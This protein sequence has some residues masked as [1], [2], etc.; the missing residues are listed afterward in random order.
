MSLAM[1]GRNASYEFRWRRWALLRDTAALHL[2]DGKSGTRFPRFASIGDALIDPLRIPARELADEIRAMQPALARHPV[3]ALVLG[4][5]TAAILYMGARL[6]SPRPLTNAEIAQISPLGDARNL[7][8][9]F[10]SMLDSMSHV[11]QHAADDG[12]IEVI[13]G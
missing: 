7:A 6:E 12:T 10:A 13:D 11:C 5:A 8:E 1:I 3:T 4:P 2:E 9:Y